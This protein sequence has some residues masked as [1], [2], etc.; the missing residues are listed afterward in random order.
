MVLGLPLYFVKNGNLLHPMRYTGKTLLGIGIMGEALNGREQEVNFKTL[1]AR[2]AL[3]MQYA[4][5]AVVF[6]QKEGG[7]KIEAEIS[8]LLDEVKQNE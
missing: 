6:R 5:R 1:V 3:N 2:N 7:E 8:R 4:H